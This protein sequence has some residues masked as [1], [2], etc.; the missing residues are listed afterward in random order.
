MRKPPRLT[1]ARLRE[2][3]HYDPKTGHFCGR[4]G[5]GSAYMAK[6]IT[7]QQQIYPA[8]Q[9]AWLY[10]TGR[11]G[12]PMIDHRDGDPTN[13]RW[14]NLRRATKSQNCANRRRAGH[15][16]SG[17]KGVCRCRESGKWR[18]SISKNG[19]WIHLGRFATPQA[20]HAA[21]AD[22][23]RKLFGEFARVE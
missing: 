5:S 17:F 23:A 6:L 7:I 2:L 20:A 15:N 10:M 18:A 11:W 16:T 3:L 22:A 1:R 19:R 8:H 21:Y 4:G 13:N 12:R 9:L 14:A